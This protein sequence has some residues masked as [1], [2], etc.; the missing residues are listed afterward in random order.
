ME[1]LSH[2][3][4]VSAQLRPRRVRPDGES[5]PKAELPAPVESFRKTPESSATTSSKP[6]GVSQAVGAAVPGPLGP[7][8]AQ[9]LKALDPTDVEAWDEAEK[10]YDVIRASQ[11][12]V[13]RI[14]EFSPYS[15][16]EV[17]VIK[18]HLFIND[19]VLDDRVGRF[20]ADPLIANAWVRLDQGSYGPKDL[21]LLEHELF[22][23]RF[24]SLFDTDYRTAHDA[25]NRS[26]RTSGLYEDT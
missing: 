2:R 20:D 10:Q 22:E 11:S 26:G 4:S 8:L 6:Q 7:A 9:Q 24:E 25:A 16:K 17:T 13:D 15:H 12:D 1:K 3:H 5:S 14:A 21:Q 23:A 18:N 19:H